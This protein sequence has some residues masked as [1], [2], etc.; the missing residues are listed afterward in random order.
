MPKEKEAVRCPECSST[1]VYFRVKT[2]DYQCQKC[3]YCGKIGG[4]K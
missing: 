2:K 4:K 3:G 1:Q